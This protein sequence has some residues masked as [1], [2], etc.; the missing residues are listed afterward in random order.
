MP[1][2]CVF[3]CN[4]PNGHRFSNRKN[5]LKVSNLGHFFVKEKN[6]NQDKM[7]EFCK[8]HFLETDFDE[9][10]VL[11]KKFVPN[12]REQYLEIG[13]VKNLSKTYQKQWWPKLLRFW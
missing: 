4:E 10:S 6:F 12:S 7:L 11:K 13:F 1:M 5:R 8:K 9:S 3:G 2:C